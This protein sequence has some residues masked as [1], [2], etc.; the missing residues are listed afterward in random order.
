MEAMW[1]WQAKGAP[2]LAV[3]GLTPINT[4]YFELGVPKNSAHPNLAKL[5]VA[6]MARLLDPRQLGVNA[7]IQIAASRPEVRAAF[8][9]AAETL[10]VV[11]AGDRE[12]VLGE[13]RRIA[14]ALPAAAPVPAPASIPAPAPVRS[15]PPKPSRRR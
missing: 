13:I 14:D 4:D 6:F 3:P 7:D 10:Q 2:L 1:A 15:R 8:A 11:L 5:L 9:D 12:E